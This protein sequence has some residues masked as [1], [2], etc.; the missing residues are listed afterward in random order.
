MKN[1]CDECGKTA[2][3]FVLVGGR[4]LCGVCYK[5]FY[6]DECRKIDQAKEE[7]RKRVE[8]MKWLRL[9]DL[10]GYIEWSAQFQGLDRIID[11]LDE[12][13]LLVHPDEFNQSPEVFF[14]QEFQGWI[15]DWAERGGLHRSLS[16][17]RKPRCN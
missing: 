15:D 8:Q 9:I 11:D 1:R 7:G 12:Y 14:E 3:G 6:P 2:P 10:P 16:E 5:R 13:H 4:H 17:F